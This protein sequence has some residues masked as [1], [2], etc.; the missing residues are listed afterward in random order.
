MRKMEFLRKLDQELAML[1]TKERDDV[2]NDYDEHFMAGYEAGKSDEDIINSLGTPEEIAQEI[3]EDSNIE[4][5]KQVEVLNQIEAPSQ[6]NL[7]A[8]IMLLIF[9]AL[10]GFWVLLSV[11]ILIGALFFTGVVMLSSPVLYMVAIPWQ[12]FRLYEFFLGLL[13]SGCGYFLTLGMWHVGKA[14]GRFITDHI[15]QMN[16]LAG[17]RK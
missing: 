12:G 7:G 4:M 16:H 8:F 9:H 17:G 2:L 14:F 13:F 1:G 15:Q 10:V 11:G 5:P 6:R 3:L